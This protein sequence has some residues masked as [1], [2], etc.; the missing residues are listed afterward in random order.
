MNERNEYFIF[1][2]KSGVGMVN[3]ET[4][5]SIAMNGAAYFLHYFSP[6]FREITY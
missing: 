6:S 5:S 3:D 4:Q 1:E 2:D